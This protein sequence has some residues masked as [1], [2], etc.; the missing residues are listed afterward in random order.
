M[1]KDK[2]TYHSSDDFEL[3]EEVWVSCAP[4]LRWST[5]M[6]DT[7]ILPK[8]WEAEEGVEL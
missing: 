2:D 5:T 8:G 7:V 6:I 4:P 3:S 1:I